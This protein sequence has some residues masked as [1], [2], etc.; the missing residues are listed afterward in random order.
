MSRF[1][2]AGRELDL[3][4]EQV[5]QALRGR[6]PERLYAHGVVVNG[7]IWPP[8]QV[9]EVVSGFDRLDFTTQEARRVL[10][11][12]G[13]PTIRPGSGEGPGREVQSAGPGS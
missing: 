6:R 2:V 5:E 9:F 3:D 13:F 1:R 11:A 7:E 12:L 4:R 8:K 10:K